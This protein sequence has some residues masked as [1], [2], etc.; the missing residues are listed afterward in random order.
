MV[1]PA[2]KPPPGRRSPET[3]I[4]ASLAMGPGAFP[5][6]AAGEVL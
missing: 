1:L 2:R 6:L 5:G 3:T 4:G